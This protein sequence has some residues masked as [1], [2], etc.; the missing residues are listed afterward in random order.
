MQFVHTVHR[1]G[2]TRFSAHG[3]YESRGTSTIRLL[4][5]AMFGLRLENCEFLV[6]TADQP[7]PIGN[8]VTFSFSTITDDYSFTCPDFLF[9][10]W[11]EVRID[12]YDRLCAEIRRTGTIEPQRPVAGWIGVPMVE[13]RQ[14]LVQL[15]LAHSDLVQAIDMSWD[16]KNPK[17]LSS[18]K[19]MSLPDQVRTWK[20]LIDIEG[21]G[22][23]ARLKTFLFSGRP[24]LVVDRPWKEWFFPN[25]E[26]WVHF[27][28]VR[29][30]LTDLTEAVQR[31]N[32][33]PAL[34]RSIAEN[35]ARFAQEFLTRD[36]AL[37]HWRSL[38]RQ[39][40]GV[41]TEKQLVA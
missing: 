3:C 2:Q 8:Q 11:P 37:L 32:S 14:K 7:G 35:A 27:V 18:P 10:S 19:Y 25:L 40:F 41:K 21:C 23:S 15:S 20:Y 24:T 30:D 1:A 31:L 29:R 6:N 9:D 13:A 34:A 4:Q 5:R 28:P 16:R 36:A 39:H 38:L 33:D 26:P 12:D 17:R 22:W